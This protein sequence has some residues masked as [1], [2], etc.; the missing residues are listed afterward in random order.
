MWLLVLGYA[1]TI[2]TALWYVSKAKGEDLCLN[3]L[4]TILW[5]ATVMFFVDAVY[6]Y[7]SGEEFIEIS[8]EATTLGFSLL[9][10][11]LVVWLFILFS[12]DPK[13][14]FRKR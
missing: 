5:G 11:A 10:V 7:L 2:T 3:Y 9:L 1:A 13:R 8:T 4:A 12:K 6:S 14:V